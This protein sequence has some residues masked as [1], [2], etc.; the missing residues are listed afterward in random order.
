MLEFLHVLH[1]ER[2]LLKCEIGMLVTLLYNKMIHLISLDQS[3]L[4]GYHN[5]GNFCWRPRVFR[6]PSLHTCGHRTE[7]YGDDLRSDQLHSLDAFEIA[8][9]SRFLYVH[10]E[11]ELL[12]AIPGTI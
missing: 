3:P 12:Y 7:T 8:Y 1:G 11:V 10:M 4:F 5:W 6:V 9:D 2:Q